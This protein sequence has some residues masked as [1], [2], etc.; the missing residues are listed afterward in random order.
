VTD[1]VFDTHLFNLSTL[2]DLELV[3]LNNIYQAAFIET[4]L[5]LAYIVMVDFCAANFNV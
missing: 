5:D 4:T 2:E 1:A 3:C